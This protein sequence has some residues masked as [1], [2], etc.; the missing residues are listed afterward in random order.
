MGPS[1]SDLFLYYSIDAVMYPKISGIYI[2]A[3]RSFPPGLP[4]LRFIFP[5][6]NKFVVGQAGA[7][8]CVQEVV[9]HFTLRPTSN[10]K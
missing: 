10:R 9:T 3:F 2:C 1:E 7:G 5:P 8:G 4:L 6:S